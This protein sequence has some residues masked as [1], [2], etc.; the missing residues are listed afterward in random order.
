MK[1]FTKSIGLLALTSA[2]LLSFHADA[3]RYCISRI[4]SITNTPSGI[5]VRAHSPYSGAIYD[6]MELSYQDQNLGSILEKLAEALNS[7]KRVRV[8]ILE[9]FNGDDGRNCTDGVPDYI[10]SV[11]PA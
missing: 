6:P 2:S 4:D 11:H 5:V 3:G 7:R 9:E 8:Y 1:N 10:G